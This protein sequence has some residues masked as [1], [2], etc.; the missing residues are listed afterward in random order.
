MQQKSNRKLTE[1]REL[2][3]RSDLLQPGDVILTAETS[4]SSKTVRYSTGGPY[5]HAMLVIDE[6]NRFD[7]C[8]SGIRCVPA[9]IDKCEIHNGQVRWFN[10]IS[11]HLRFDVFRHPDL[12]SLGPDEQQ[13]LSKRM[14]EFVMTWGMSEYRLERLA[15]AR[16]RTNLQKPIRLLARVVS[17]FR[18]FGTPV[19][20]PFC[21]ELVAMFFQEIGVELFDQPTEPSFVNPSML[22]DSESNLVKRDDFKCELDQT[23]PHAATLHT[24][25][26]AIEDHWPLHDRQ[27]LVAQKVAQAHAQYAANSL[28]PTD[29]LRDAA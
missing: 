29:R 7:K 14:S 18:W 24:D 11:S 27:R 10:A 15:K 28:R 22:S 5:S 6:L 8:G 23:V 2:F 9:R 20:G 21:S 19:S 25:I 12:E 26:C 1:D 16:T 4:A 17:S 3:L 13:E